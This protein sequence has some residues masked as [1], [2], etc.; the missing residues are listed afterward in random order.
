MHH[1]GIMLSGEDIP[2]AT[3]VC[4]KLID[5]FDVLYS[6]AGKTLIAQIA[7][8]ELVGWRLSILVAFQ[9]NPA[10]PKAFISEPRDKM[11]TDKST[12]ACDKDAFHSPSSFI[13]SLLFPA[14]YYNKP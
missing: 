3:H 5:L 7:H 11:A 2:G 10:Y 1:L 8:D 4:R 13:V 14:N 6:P 12:S 9:I